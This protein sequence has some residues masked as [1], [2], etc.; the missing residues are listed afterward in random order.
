VGITSRPD[1][2]RTATSAL[3]AG[4]R[5]PDVTAPDPVTRPTDP[6]STTRRRGRGTTAAGLGCVTVLVVALVAV[7]M[8][9]GVYALWA[10]GT[11]RVP[12]TSE[13]REACRQPETVSYDGTTGYA[14][15]VSEPSVSLSLAPS[16]P[17]AIVSRIGDGSYGVIVE[18]GSADD[19]GEVEC[20]WEADGVTIVEPGGIAHVVPADVFSG[21]R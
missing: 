4:A 13:R 17:R 2:H 14:V 6:P 12:E 18:L 11:G 1:L 10:F 15:F 16:A 21:G 19:A 9:V 7:A 3:R 5:I 20:R 8:A